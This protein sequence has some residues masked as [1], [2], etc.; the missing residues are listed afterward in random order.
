MKH[1]ITCRATL[2]ATERER[3][4]DVWTDLNAYPSWDEREEVNKLDGPFGPGTTGTFKQRGRGAGRYT[5]VAVEPGRSWTTHIALPGG[6]LEIE[7]FVEGEAG[8]VEVVKRYNIT[9]PMALL[10]K[11][12]F[13]R[14]IAK[15]MPGSFA[16]LDAEVARRAAV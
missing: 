5:I 8:A 6:L 13:A 10:F 15:Q 9:G 1:T 2:K 14:G 4:W 3:V 16:A 11:L 12:F 7:H